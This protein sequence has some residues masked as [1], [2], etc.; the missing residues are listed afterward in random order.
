MALRAPSGEQPRRSLSGSEAGL[1]LRPLRQG[2]V[3]LAME[4]LRGAGELEHGHGR[5]LDIRAKVFQRD[6]QK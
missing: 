3:A 2:E 6:E 4:E 1:L 5:G